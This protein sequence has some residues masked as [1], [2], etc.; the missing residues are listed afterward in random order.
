MS[1]KVEIKIGDLVEISVTTKIAGYFCS[2]ENG[3]CVVSPVSD[4]D[5][6]KRIK[7]PMNSITSVDIAHRP[8]IMT[9][10][11]PEPETGKLLPFKPRSS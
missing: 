4:L 8:S 1:D 2:A 3:V 6:S 9:D 11:E 7:I 5:P 10:T